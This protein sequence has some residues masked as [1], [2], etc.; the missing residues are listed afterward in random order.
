MILVIESSDSEVINALTEVAKVLKAS[1]RIE[2]EGEVVSQ[3]EKVRR[4]KIV[5]RFKGGLQKYAD[6]YQPTKHDWYQQVQH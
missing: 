6:G 4:A 3:D 2:N 1:F 5:R